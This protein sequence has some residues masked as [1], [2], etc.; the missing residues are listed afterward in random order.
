MGAASPGKAGSGSGKPART[1]P[2]GNLHGPVGALQFGV[3]PP[4][5]LLQR[6]PAFRSADRQ[7]LDAA[8]PFLP[9]P[10]ETRR[11]GKRTA[12]MDRARRRHRRRRGRNAGKTPIG[13]V[14]RRPRESSRT[15]RP[16]G[17]LRCSGQDRTGAPS[18]T[19]MRQAARRSW[20]FRRNRRARI[21]RCERAPCRWRAQKN[22]CVSDS[23]TI[24]AANVFRCSGRIL[25]PGRRKTTQSPSAFST[26][27]AR[28]PSVVPSPAPDF[29]TLS[30][31]PSGTV[32][33]ESASFPAPAR[34]TSNLR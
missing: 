26:P 12:R 31:M 27:A 30:A 34:T 11:S 7:R 4:D 6:L 15:A 9:E 14:R 32:P 13:R 28:V 23:R 5:D 24:L 21:Q 29:E 33:G 18:G 19:R 20:R 10:F 16:P 25:S 17:R 22:A 1:K 2:L 8:H 3:D